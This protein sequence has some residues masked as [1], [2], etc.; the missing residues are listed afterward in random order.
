MVRFA[1]AFEVFCWGISASKSLTILENLLAGL[2]VDF[3]DLISTQRSKHTIQHLLWNYEKSPLWEHINIRI[4]MALLTK[5][6]VF[7]GIFVK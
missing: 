6:P 5:K 4:F 1:D 2:L 7:N 3:K